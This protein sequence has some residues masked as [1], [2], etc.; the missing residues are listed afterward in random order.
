MA[1]KDYYRDYVL[2]RC[3]PADFQKFTLGSVP[4]GE[5]DEYL[6]PKESLICLLPD[7][8]AI[9]K[10]C[11]F[12]QF[13]NFLMFYAQEDEPWEVLGGD[14]PQPQAP[15][16]AIVAGDKM[17]MFLRKRIECGPDPSAAD[18]PQTAKRSIN[19]QKLALL[20]DEIQTLPRIKPPGLQ[21]STAA[22]TKGSIVN[23]PVCSLGSVRVVDSTTT[24]AHIQEY[25][26]AHPGCLAVFEQ[27]EEG[28]GWIIGEAIGVGA[29]KA[30]A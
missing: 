13:A 16:H 26:T 11:A 2:V 18:R 8:E 7:G 25:I 19:T 23:A 15:K 12:G 24:A 30:S 20:R 21:P 3:I 1:D 5:H 9:R 10:P 14:Q 17:A 22:E 29:S 6:F 4:Q 28:S 27:E